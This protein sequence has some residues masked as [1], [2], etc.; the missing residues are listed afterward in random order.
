[1]VVAKL[2]AI[3]INKRKKNVFFFLKLKLKWGEF[4]GY[5]TVDGEPVHHPRLSGH[6]LKPGPRGN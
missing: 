2:L 6:H 4:E 1:M 3:K 5:A